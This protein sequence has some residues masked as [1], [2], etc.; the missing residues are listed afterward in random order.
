MSAIHFTLYPG[1]Q[2]VDEPSLLIFRQLHADGN[3]IPLIET[4]SAA[5]GTC[6]LS[7]E[8]RMSTH[9]SL[10]AV[11]WYDSRR[12]PFSYEILRMAP[13]GIQT[14]FFSIF[15]FSRTEMELCTE[16]RLFQLIQSLIYSLHFIL[17]LSVTLFHKASH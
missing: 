9:G 11:I 1:H 3:T 10:S 2:Q 8:N 12:K 7:L 16:I 13:Y 17:S 14:F 4:S 15:P 6:M 5:A